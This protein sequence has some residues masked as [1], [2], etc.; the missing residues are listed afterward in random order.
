MAR[1][2]I[3]WAET[4]ALFV[5]LYAGVVLGGLALDRA[6]GS[7][8]FPGELRP[9]GLALVLAG[10]AGI[11]WCFALLVRVGGGTPNPARPTTAL[12]TSG[13]FAWTRNPVMG[14]H[15][16]AGL[17]VAL[18]VGSPAAAGI[19]VAFVPPAYALARHEE[20]ILE[21]RF[22]DAYRAYRA[23]VPRFVPRP[24]RRQSR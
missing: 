17:G 14:S 19:V 4:A 15:L 16:V 3:A 23:S 21:A 10:A 22:G 12:V 1:P 5:S 8:P 11:A 2:A 7:R 6:V 24:P 18:L 9:A 20:R 13:P